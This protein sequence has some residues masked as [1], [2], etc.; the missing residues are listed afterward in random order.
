M[1][2]SYSAPTP[3]LDVQ[4]SPLRMKEAMSLETTAGAGAL[5]KLFGGAAL[6]GGAAA[7]IGYVVMWPR[8]RRE[9][10]SRFACSIAA[11]VTFGPALAIAMHSV[12]PGLF[13][14]AGD[15]AVQAGQARDL[16]LLV[17]SVPFLVFAALPAWWLLGGLM[18][19][20]DKRRDKD[21][22]EMAQDA[23][24]VVRDVREAL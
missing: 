17:V 7:A 23:A 12:W 8:T 15:L 22:G 14:S 10:V 18:L 4:T 5:I 3:D 2:R 16:G 6:A 21:L 1:G 11:S 9:A 19:W 13:A 24:G 20:L